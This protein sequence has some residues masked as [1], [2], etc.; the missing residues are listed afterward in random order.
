MDEAVTPEEALARDFTA[1]HANIDPA[2]AQRAANLLS[3]RVAELAAEYEMTSP[4]QWNNLLVKAGWASRGLCCHWAEDLVAELLSLDLATLETHWVVAHHRS[5]LR[6]HNSVVVVA[7]GSHWNR[8]IVVDPW[9]TSGQLFWTPLQS[10]SYPWQ[11]H[12][13]SGNWADLHCEE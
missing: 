3:H 6:E 7:A 1:L 9:R 11:L 5:W 12:P 10:D 2:E 4:P 13:L 8:G